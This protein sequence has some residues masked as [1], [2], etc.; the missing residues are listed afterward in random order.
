MRCGNPVAHRPLPR[1]PLLGLNPHPGAKK[2]GVWMAPCNLRRSTKCR[3]TLVFKGPQSSGAPRA[4]GYLCTGL[5]NH[6][7][8]KAF[9]RA[10]EGTTSC[11]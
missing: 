8:A 2:L 4:R 1:T 5:G 6:G 9:H 10:L 7:T 11:T 3:L